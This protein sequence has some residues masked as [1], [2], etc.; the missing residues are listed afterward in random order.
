[1]NVFR[2]DRVVLIKELP[3]MKEVGLTYEVGDINAK[4]VI[5][6][7]VKSKVAI[8]AI[9]I[10]TFDEYF[11]KP[12]EVRTWTKWMAVSNELGDIIAYYRTNLKKVQVKIPNNDNEIKAECCC[13]K[14]DDFNLHFG[15]QLAYKRC[16]DKRYKKDMEQYQTALMATESAIKDNRNQMKRMINLLDNEC[17]LKELKEKVEE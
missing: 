16:L 15:I 12:E 1:M 9:D 8:C 10:E 3:K 13:C 2:G 6:R 17:E 14:E 4:N 5:L 11:T 7:D